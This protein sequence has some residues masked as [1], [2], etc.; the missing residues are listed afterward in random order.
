VSGIRSRPVSSVMKAGGLYILG[1]A[2][3]CPQRSG[4]LFSGLIVSAP[5][6]RGRFR[7]LA[8][9][10]RPRP[11]RRA[12]RQEHAD[13]AVLHPARRPGVLPGHPRP[14]SRPFLRNP[15]SSTA[16]T[17]PGSPRFLTTYRHTASRQASSSHGEKFSSRCI[18]SGDASPANS[19]NCHEFFRSVCDS[20]PRAYARLCLRTLAFEKNPRPA[21]TAR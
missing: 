3:S 4:P 15:V 7:Q 5:A 13:L 19:A 16:K 14:T 20:S 12:V 8:V 21:R 9:D 1:G 18:P 6:G 17:A 10:Q 2:K 11:V